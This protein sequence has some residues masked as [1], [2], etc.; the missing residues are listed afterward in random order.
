MYNYPERISRYPWWKILCYVVTAAL[1]VTAIVV[2]L[3]Q[4]FIPDTAS[5]AAAAGTTSPVPITPSTTINLLGSTGSVLSYAVGTVLPLVVAYF[6]TA[7]MSATA[8]GLILLGLSTLSAFLT[9]W[10]QAVQSNLPFDWA[11]AIVVS[12]VTF[13]VGVLT[14]KGAWGA[15]G[16]A[17]LSHRIKTTMGVTS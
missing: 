6:T 14:H 1:L 13:A 5:A 3:V 8:R 10:L 11:S 17:S 9:Q 2:A 16:T 4:L 7:K 12:I 15:G